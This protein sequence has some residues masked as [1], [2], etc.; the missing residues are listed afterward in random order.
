M[1]QNLFKNR[2]NSSFFITDSPIFSSTTSFSSNF[3]YGTT[4]NPIKSTTTSTS[5]PTDPELDTNYILKEEDVKL[6]NQNVRRTCSKAKEIIS[7]YLKYKK[8]KT[9]QLLINEVSTLNNSSQVTTD[10]APTSD[11][12]PSSAS[13]S[14]ISLQEA[15]NN[16]ILE[17][18]NE[19]KNFWIEFYQKHSSYMSEESLQI[20]QKINKLYVENVKTSAKISVLRQLKSSKTE[21]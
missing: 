3:S 6:I 11:S 13:I 7:N 18:K 10:P 8:N 21:E 12:S 1:N 17:S 4:S 2:E 19:E 5:T 14:S 16:L 20:L 15:L 9:N